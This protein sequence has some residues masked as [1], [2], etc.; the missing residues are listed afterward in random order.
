MGL[1]LKALNSI[2]GSE[3]VER[4]GLRKPAARLVYRAT[5]DGSRAAGTRR[6]HLHR[7][8]AARARPRG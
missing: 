6:P 2:A 7:G 8:D 4:L 5:R 3:V 1:G